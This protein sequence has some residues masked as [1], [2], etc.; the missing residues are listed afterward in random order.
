MWCRVCRLHQPTFTPTYWRTLLFSNRQTRKER[1]RPG[2][3]RRP[4]QQLCNGKL[5]CL[6]YELFFIKKIRPCLNTQSD[7]IRAKLSLFYVH[8]FTYIFYAFTCI[9]YALSPCTVGIL[10]C[11]DFILFHLKMM[12]W[13][14]R[15]L[16]H[17]SFRLFLSL[18]AY[19]SNSL[20]NQKLG[21]KIK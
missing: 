17:N 12:T 1:P 9:F 11:Q 21:Q 6:I 14:H 18:N 4:Y 5:D 16:V 2:N 19:T 3:H 10:C 13:S 20:Y 8:I 15:N 7:S